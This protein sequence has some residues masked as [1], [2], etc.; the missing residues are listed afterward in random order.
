MALPPG[1][2]FSNN[3]GGGGGDTACLKYYP[4]TGEACTLELG[5]SNDTDDHIYLNP[6][7]GVG[8]G[9]QVPEARLDVRQDGSTKTIAIIRGSNG[10]YQPDWPNWYGGLAT[11][12]I[13]CSGIYYNGLQIRSD[14]RRKTDVETYTRGL[15]DVTQLRPVRFN[16]KDEF[17][18]N[19]TEKQVGFIAQEVEQI[20]PE[21]IGEDNLGYKNI[22]QNAYVP[23]LVNAIK[24]LNTKLE[25][26]KT[27][28]NTL[29]NQIQQLFQHLGVTPN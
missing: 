15:N 5:I 18:Y 2:Y 21:I 4:R 1:Y 16:W 7:G 14:I 24:E 26:S 13:T 17:C 19:G 29:T 28:I 27:E 25:E 10:S 11:N 6:S 3:P 23:I 22:N 8:V 20:I 12:D 9:I